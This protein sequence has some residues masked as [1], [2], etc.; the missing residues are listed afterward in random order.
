MTDQDKGNVLDWLNAIIDDP[1]NWKQWYSDS[2]VKVLAEH[3]KEM[4][5][6]F[7]R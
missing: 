6:Y 7:S 2:E 1:E 4:F 3:A 5:V